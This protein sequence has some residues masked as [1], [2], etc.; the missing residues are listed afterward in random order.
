M[1]WRQ[2]TPST[3]V[4]M[5]EETVSLVFWSIAKVDIGKQNSLLNWSLGMLTFWLHLLICSWIS[6]GVLALHCNEILCW[7][8]V[9]NTWTLPLE[10]SKMSCICIQLIVYVSCLCLTMQFWCLLLHFSCVQVVGK[11]TSQLLPILHPSV[12]DFSVTLHIL[13]YRYTI[14][15]FFNIHISII[16]AHCVCLFVSVC[17]CVYLCTFCVYVCVFVSLNS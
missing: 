9:G 10:I 13:Y 1:F 12:L 16:P 6:F 8:G 4:D 14:L 7:R 11:H 5:L 15:T 17:V 3:D 2:I